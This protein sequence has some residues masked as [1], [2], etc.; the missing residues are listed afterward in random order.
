MPEGPELRHSRDVLHRILVGQNVIRLSPTP[1]GR[2]ATK[3]PIGLAEIT[4]DLPLK[5][6][7]VDVKG[8]FMWWTLT[9]RGR[10]WYMW[11]TYGMSGSWSRSQGKHAGFIV[12]YNGSGVP[13]T[14]DTQ[15]LFFND[16]R[17]FGTVKFVADEKTHAKKLASLGPDILDEPPMDPGIF[18]E[19]IL[20]KPQ[21]TICEALMDQSCISGCGNYL[22][23]EALYRSGI[24]PHRLVV[25]LSSQDIYKLQYEL[26]SAAWESYV[27]HGA[28]I[29]TYRTVDG[30]KGSAQFHFRVYNLKECPEGHPVKR[31]DTLDG[32]TSWWCESCQV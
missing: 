3:D 9:G 24:S 32:R 25:D 14:R 12:E 19:R 29:R 27:D 1:N 13:I 17:R 7:S 10:T 23:S 16:T 2:Y 15:H 11:S 6:E 18:A 4:G 28:T 31:E 20:L 30:D 8:K 22:K 26:L 21:R 5:V